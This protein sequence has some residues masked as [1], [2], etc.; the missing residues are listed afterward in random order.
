MFDSD[1]FLMALEW[2]DIY[3]PYHRYYDIYVMS[4]YVI[5]SENETTTFK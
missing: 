5:S 2:V 1:K 3:R 4:L